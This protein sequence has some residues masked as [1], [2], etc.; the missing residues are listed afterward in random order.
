MIN[1]DA[2]N[3]LKRY[4]HNVKEF[5]LP[6]FNTCSEWLLNVYNSIDALWLVIMFTT[7]VGYETEQQC[8]QQMLEWI[9]HEADNIINF[10]E[11]RK[12]DEK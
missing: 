4:F 6:Q 11:E 7:P 2:K 8:E 9:Q 3:S 10:D 1:P 5:V 12:N